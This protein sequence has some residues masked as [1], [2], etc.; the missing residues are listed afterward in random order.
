MD[1]FRSGRDMPVGAAGVDAVLEGRLPA[2]GWA[3]P[4]KSK[5]SNESLGL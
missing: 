4:K 5:P 3:L 2:E 1:C